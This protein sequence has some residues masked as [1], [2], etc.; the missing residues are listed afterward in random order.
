MKIRNKMIQKKKYKYKKI[1]NTNKIKIRNVDLATYW[2]KI[3]RSITKKV[4]KEKKERK[5]QWK[6]QNKS[7]LKLLINTIIVI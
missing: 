7:Q 3:S 1:N 4:K 2:D 6:Y 5:Y